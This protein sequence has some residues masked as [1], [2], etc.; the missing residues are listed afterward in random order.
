MRKSIEY[1][2]LIKKIVR[3]IGSGGLLLLTAPV[4]MFAVLVR[5]F[6]LVRFGIL[7]SERIGHFA[8][9]TEA[10]LCGLDQEPS[11]KFRV[12]I[13]GCLEPVCN[14]YLKQMWKRTFPITSGAYLWRLLDRSCQFW[15][16]G[17][18]HHAKMDGLSKYYKYLLIT[19]PH[20]YFTDE[21][22][23]LGRELLSQLDIPVGSKWV[24]V[25]N[26][27]S[28]YLKKTLGHVQQ[29]SYH[30]YR[31]FS[32][33]SMMSAAE[34]LA[35]RGYY[36]IRLGAIQSETHSSSNRKIIDYASS[37]HR[38][39]FGDIYLSSGCSFYI[40]SDSGIAC[41]P[42]IFRKPVCFINF[43]LTAVD[44][45]PKQQCYRLPFITKHLFHKKK[46]RFLSLREMFEAGLHNA[47]QSHRFVEAGVEVV[48]NTPEEICDL[49]IEVSERLKGQWQPQTE[50]ETLQQRFW[51]LVRRYA[52]KSNWGDIKPLIGSAFLRQHQ[53]LLE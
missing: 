24:C 38:S 28:A 30:D 26:R 10:Y 36:V 52:L 15:T 19:P 7:R 21:E 53:Y 44:L 3:K 22:K 50:D 35:G 27:D 39:D 17:D 4:V 25:H 37:P 34:E 14:L 42:L 6:V 13:I 33:H 41:L 49:A 29:W 5:P 8:A 32:I 9:D 12:D 1:N 45:I 2:N 31:D 11:A 51:E 46:S 47:G 48:S 43:T 23:Q 20:L 40:G 16:R 18:I